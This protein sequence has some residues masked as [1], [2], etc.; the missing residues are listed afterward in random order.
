VKSVIRVV[1]VVAIVVAVAGALL[2]IVSLSKAHDVAAHGDSVNF[3]GPG[4]VFFGVV[5]VAALVLGRYLLRRSR[6]E[7]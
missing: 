7:R 4:F 3:G 5:S 2:A 1:G 6:K